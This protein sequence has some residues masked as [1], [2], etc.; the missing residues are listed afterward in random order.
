MHMQ[1]GV[2]QMDVAKEKMLQK[3]KIYNNPTPQCLQSNKNTCNKDDTIS[4]SVGLFG[5]S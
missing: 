1:K 2:V 4:P 3:P 5:T